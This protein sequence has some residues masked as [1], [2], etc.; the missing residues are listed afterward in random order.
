MRV[1][2]EGERVVVGEGFRVVRVRAE[3]QGRPS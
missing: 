1:E 3:R 2:G